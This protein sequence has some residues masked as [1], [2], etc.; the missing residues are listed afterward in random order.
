MDKQKTVSLGK[1]NFTYKKEQHTPSTIQADTLLIP[2][3]NLAKNLLSI[4]KYNV[5]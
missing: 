4:L 1:A 2:Q 3:L 5:K